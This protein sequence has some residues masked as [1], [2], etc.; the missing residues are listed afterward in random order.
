MNKRGRRRF[1]LMLTE[2]VNTISP[3]RPRSHPYLTIGCS[4][5]Q[6]SIAINTHRWLTETKSKE[7]VRLTSINRYKLCKK[8]GFIESLYKI[9]DHRW[10]ASPALSR[11]SEW[12]AAKD[13]NAFHD[14]SRRR[15][16]LDPA[17]P[18]LAGWRD[19]DCNWNVSKFKSC[20]KF[21]QRNRQY[22]EK[23]T[24][25]CFQKCKRSK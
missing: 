22:K 6:S 7:R 12:M 3:N 23:D 21:T 2:S 19:F 1:Y 11:I 14:V 8:V 25:N 20:Q 5:S 15:V 10:C 9:K 16:F 13:T 17:R 4:Q 18:G 24:K